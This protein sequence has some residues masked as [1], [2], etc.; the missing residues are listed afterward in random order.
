MRGT[1]VA[2]GFGF[3]LAYFPTGFVVA[4]GCGVAIDAGIAVGAAS[5]GD[6]LELGVGETAEAGEGTVVAVGALPLVGA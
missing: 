4:E 1:G 2:L 3:G 6:A 5:T